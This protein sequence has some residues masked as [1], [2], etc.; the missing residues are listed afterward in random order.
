MLYSHCILQVLEDGFSGSVI[1][2]SEQ[3]FWYLEL[4]QTKYSFVAIWEKRHKFTLNHTILYIANANHSSNI[5]Q[6]KCKLSKLFKLYLLEC[7]LNSQHVN[8][9][10][11]VRISL[12]LC[13]WSIGLDECWVIQNFNWI[14]MVSRLQYPIFHSNS[15]SL[16]CLTIEFD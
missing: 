8:C 5:L 14:E 4:M 12:W 6:P 15:M 9:V 3:H 7:N 16:G 11:V 10:G 1:S 13:V 2:I